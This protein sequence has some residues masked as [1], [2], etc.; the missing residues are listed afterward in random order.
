MQYLV[1]PGNLGGQSCYFV[2]VPPVLILNL[3]YPPF[4]GIIVLVGLLNLHVT[5][6]EYSLNLIL[7]S[8]LQLLVLLLKLKDGCLIFRNASK[9][10]L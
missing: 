4:K 3:K 6:P 1:Q 9:V 10:E 7:P 2:L 8:S 5:L